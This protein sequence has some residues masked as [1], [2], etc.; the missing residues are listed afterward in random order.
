M[1]E[2]GTLDIRSAIDGQGRSAFATL[3]LLTCSAVM[4]VEG[5]DAQVVAY[6]APAIIRAWHIDR[7]AFGPVFGASLFGYMVGATVLSG[8]SDRFGRR[9][10][11]AASNLVF[12]LFT[13]ASAFAT[14]ITG[15]L[16]FRFLAGLGLGCSIPATI[17]LAVEFAPEQRR[18]FRVSLLFVGYTV[19]AAL[20]GVVAAALMTWFGWQS[21]FLLGAGLSAALGLAALALLPE[22]VRFLAARGTQPGQIA[23]IM[24]RLRP[25]LGITPATRFVLA[26]EA[27]P[28]GMP[29]TQL[30]SDG[31]AWIT[32]LLWAAFVTSLGSHYFL[33]SWI[34]T[35][36]DAGGI[37]LAHAVV[38]G[39]LIQAGGGLGSLLLGRLVD[40]LG[41]LSIAAALLLSTPLVVLIGAAGWS[42]PVL[43]ALVF[44]AG[45][46]L[47]GGQIGL[48]ALASTIYP[49]TARS[50][51]A[52]WALGIGRLGSIMGPVI[53][54]WLIGAGLST[55]AL[56]VCAAIPAAL[57]GMFVVLL[58]RASSRP[59]PVRFQL[60]KRPGSY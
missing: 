25:D 46:F 20:G 35:V 49:T 12:A 15:L 55:P 24:R 2:A 43:M 38:A 40:R 9:R 32:V 33:T 6:A 26:E 37:P 57:S 60:A 39:S 29:V 16:S 44:L 31:R 11:I 47:L 4:V 5:Y 8:A 21:A 48:N 41:M 19:G 30:F 10:V 27:A 18:S 14:T 52:G 59:A 36:L 34:P 51:G 28:K 50:S 22:S 53:G 23:A 45:M 58:A 3:I 1:S 13:L 17:A 56:F 7:S 54:G 42:E